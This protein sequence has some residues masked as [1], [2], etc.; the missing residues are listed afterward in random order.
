[1]NDELRINVLLDINEVTALV[2][3]CD[4]LGTDMY[5]AVRMAIREG[6]RAIAM[7]MYRQGYA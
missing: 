2:L 1:M 7:R 5:S 4:L 6:I 3:L